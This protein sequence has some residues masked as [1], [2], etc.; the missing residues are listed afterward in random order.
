M[1]VSLSPQ[2]PTNISTEINKVLRNDAKNTDRKVEKLCNG[3]FEK[4]L[5]HLSTA[6]L[7][8]INKINENNINERNDDINK[9]KTELNSLQESL[10][11]DPSNTEIQSK[12][13]ACEKKIKGL[14]AAKKLV[15]L[16]T[17]QAALNNHSQIEVVQSIRPKDI[18]ELESKFANERIMIN[19]QDYSD[20]DPTT[21][22]SSRGANCFLHYGKIEYLGKDQ[23]ANNIMK[24]TGDIMKPESDKVFTIFAAAHRPITNG[25]ARG[26]N[27]QEENFGFQ[28]NGLAIKTAIKLEGADYFPFDANDD[29]STQY[30]PTPTLFRNITQVAEF[31]YFGGTTLRNV[32]EQEIEKEYKILP[33]ENQVTFSALSIAAPSNWKDANEAKKANLITQMIKNW[34]QG[35]EAV[36]IADQNKPVQT[37]GWGTG[38]FSGSVKISVAAQ[39]IAFSLMNKEM[40]FYW[41]DKNKEQ[42]LKDAFKW[43]K[44]NL[45]NK[46]PNEAIELLVKELK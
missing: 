31:S 12:I 3:A 6:T 15:E 17:N 8:R 34:V 10:Q 33:K 9:T 13:S 40:H 11:K 18:Q 41:V 4:Q 23:R 32:T 27:S 38:A 22:T 2:T 42:E 39:C 43:C 25:A 36:D 24:T 29:K 20:K 35:L 37:G 14:S 46:T 7:E 1:S 21:K 44:E 26:G 16:A 19:Y 5:I 30:N 45:E 28:T